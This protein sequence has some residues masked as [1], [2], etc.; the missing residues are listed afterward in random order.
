MAKTEEQA[1][2]VHQRVL[3][4]SEELDQDL[5]AIQAAGREWGLRHDHPEGVFVTAMMHAIKRTGELT[6]AATNDLN[7][8]AE[9]SRKT[10]QVELQRLGLANDQALLL[11]EHARIERVN[12]SQDRDAQVAKMVAKLGEDLVTGVRDWTVMRERELNRKWAFNRAVIASLIAVSIFVGGY[13]ARLYQENETG[14]SGVPCKASSLYRAANG[15][16][17][18]KVSGAMK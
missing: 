10:A 3:R 1:S 4:L 2:L 15:E 5:A 13:G 14:T 8:V 17:W 18:C 6:V 11:V 16:I 7:A 9:T 12:F